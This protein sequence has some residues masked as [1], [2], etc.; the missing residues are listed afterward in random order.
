MYLAKMVNKLSFK[1]FQTAFLQGA[2][3]AVVGE[4]IQVTLESINLCN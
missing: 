3:S 2:A 4:D 1:Q